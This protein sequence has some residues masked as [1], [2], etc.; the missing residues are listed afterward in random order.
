MDQVHTVQHFFCASHGRSLCH[1]NEHHRIDPKKL[2]SGHHDCSTKAVFLCTAV[3]VQSCHMSGCQNLGLGIMGYCSGI[4]CLEFL[5]FLSA[6]TSEKKKGIGNPSCDFPSLCMVLA[7]HDRRYNQSN[8]GVFTDAH[9]LAHWTQRTGPSP[10]S[11]CTAQLPF[12]NLVNRMFFSNSD[13]EVQSAGYNSAQSPTNWESIHG[14]DP[15]ILC[16]ASSRL[17]IALDEKTQNAKSK[18]VPTTRETYNL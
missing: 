16:R 18:I 4:F 17:S 14:K 3:K 12:L 13:F 5:D 2:S 11:K 7:S 6:I 15:G 9:M 1:G 8:M 10:R